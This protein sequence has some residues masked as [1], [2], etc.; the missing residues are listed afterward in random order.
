M[1]SDTKYFSVLDA[2]SGYWQIKLGKESSLLTT[3]NT[4]FGRYC[5]TRM[6]FGLHSAQ[7]VF[8]K[9]KNR[10]KDVMFWPSI[11]ERSD[12]RHCLKLPSLHR[13]PEL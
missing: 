5:F 7:E 10:A 4:P 12:R 11:Y 13:T 1:L 2:T 3:L 9:N 8:Q 6:T